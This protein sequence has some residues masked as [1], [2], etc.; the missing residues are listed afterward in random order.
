MTSIG[1]FAILTVECAI[2][3][4]RIPTM[5]KNIKKLLP[6]W[7]AFNSALLMGFPTI[8]PIAATT[9]WNQ[10][11]LSQMDYFMTQWSATMGQHYTR[12]YPNAANDS[13]KQTLTQLINQLELDGQTF[14]YGLADEKPNAH[15]RIEYVYSTLGKDQRVIT[16][17]FIN[18]E[19]TPL[20]LV[21]DSNAGKA[22]NQVW[23]TQNQ[24]LSR[25]FTEFANTSN[26][27]SSSTKI[28]WNNDKLKQLDE[29]MLQWKGNYGTAYHQV[30]PDTSVPHKEY[31]TSHFFNIKKTLLEGKWYT[32]TY[33][34]S[35]ELADGITF[36]AAYSNYYEG[37]SLFKD[38]F[39]TLFFGYLSDKTPVVLEWAT[40]NGDVTM[41]RTEFTDVSDKFSEIANQ[42][43]ATNST[44]PVTPPPAAATTND[45][46]IDIAQL[47]KDLDSNPIDTIKQLFAMR[48][49][50]FSEEEAKA[51]L[52]KTL[53]KGDYPPEMK[54]NKLFEV[55]NT[56]YYAGIISMG[57]GPGLRVHFFKVGDLLFVLGKYGSFEVYSQTTEGN[58]YSTQLDQGLLG[59]VIY[60]LSNH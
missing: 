9:N 4:E 55:N 30:F 6:L 40:T 41:R 39:R 52:N 60:E 45:A 14:D 48:D 54:T 22:S 11:N 5:R 46:T 20:V 50:Q 42:P 28:D 7:L 19:G 13:D 17:Y 57:D 43:S 8:S 36:V 18:H 53:W 33:A 47:K 58:I 12:Y 16:Y 38:H 37:I 31:I 1:L 56:A 49:Q 32:I 26:W 10:S 44:Q 51:Y 59:H 23:Q 25:G 24:E 29:F 34:D 2:F 35:G 21:N 3:C 15:Y 27:N